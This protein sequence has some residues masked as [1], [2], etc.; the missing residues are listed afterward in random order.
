MLLSDEKMPVSFEDEFLVI[1]YSFISQDLLNYK[2]YYYSRLVD[3]YFKNKKPVAN[4]P[5]ENNYNSSLVTND[6][7]EQVSPISF[8]DKHAFEFQHYLEENDEDCA[9]ILGNGISIPLGA[10]PW[11]KLINNLIDYLT[12]FYIK[13]ADKVINELSKS[14]YLISSFVKSTFKTK[15]QEEIY[16]AGLKYCIYRKF[17]KEMLNE[18]TLLKADA[19]AKLK[20]RNIGILTYN[21]DNFLEQQ[22]SVCDPS[23]KIK[24][25]SAK[26]Y[27]KHFIDA[28]IHL[29]GTI[30]TSSKKL[31]SNLVL[32]DEEYFNAYLNNYGGSIRKAQEFAL[33]NKHCLYIG[34]SMSDL[35]QLSIISRIKSQSG[36]GWCCYALMSAEDLD[37]NEE[38][39][40]IKFYLEKGIRIIFA[41]SYEALKDRLNDITKCSFPISIVP[42]EKK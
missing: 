3:L 35:F 20:Y 7:V 6:V 28:I 18:N 25:F 2:P 13:N 15:G 33:V 27:R 41:K 12:P 9:F 37:E 10:D 36:D 4:V 38:N 5:K 19:L 22:I 29:H 21:Y 24:S 8:S 16:K 31:D 30:K 42:F 40:L 32:T 11:S 39:D 34:S 17:N 23:F 14:N 26:S 1:N